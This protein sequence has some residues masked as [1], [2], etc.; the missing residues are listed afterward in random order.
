MLA[1]LGA[2]RSFSLNVRCFSASA[3]PAA[4]AAPPARP[5]RL[6]P[7]ERRKLIMSEAPAKN[8]KIKKVSPKFVVS[9]FEKE[10]IK[11]LLKGR[12]I[13][14]FQVGDTISMEYLQSLKNP[15]EPPILIEGVVI[16]KRNRGLGSAFT[17]RNVFA[18]VGVERT[19]PLYSPFIKS[20]YVLHSRR[21]RR[22]KFYYVRQ[23]TTKDA[24]K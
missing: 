3:A 23:I 16:A 17:I 8:Q 15:Q 22:S 6:S 13:E 1:R 11:T 9:Q 20:L 7:V 12:Q 4:D 18:E 21:M 24:T 5:P 10:H 14:L 19:F 2:L